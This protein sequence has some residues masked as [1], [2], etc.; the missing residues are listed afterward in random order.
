MLFLSVIFAVN[1]IFT[2]EPDYNRLNVVKA[3]SKIRTEVFN[4]SLEIKEEFEK[5]A[6]RKYD[7]KNY[8]CKHKSEAFAEFLTQKGAE[9]VK[10]CKIDHKSGKYSHMVV[11]WNDNVYDATSNPSFYSIPSNK[12]FDMIKRYGFNGLRVTTSYLKNN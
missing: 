7:V 6:K 9:N 3:Q 5:I 1:V 4:E 8:N 2:V 11:I 12:Y 10:I